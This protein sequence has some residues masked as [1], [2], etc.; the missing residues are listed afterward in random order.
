[1]T[2]RRRIERYASG[3]Y[4]MIR[5]RRP[6]YPSAQRRS[7]KLQN[8]FTQRRRRTARRVRRIEDGLAGGVPP[9]GAAALAGR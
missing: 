2:N 1:M 5:R 6:L 9:S 4:K 7:H 8:G 3:D